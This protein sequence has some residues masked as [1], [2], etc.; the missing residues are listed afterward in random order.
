MRIMR[1]ILSCFIFLLT[2]CISYHA[3]AFLLEEQEIYSKDGAC[4]LRYLTEKNIKGWY[5]VSNQFNCPNEGWIDGYHDITIYNA[6]SQVEERIYGYFS[7]GYWTGDA[8]VSAP[9]L[10][11]FSEEAGVQK[12]TFL[13]AKDDSNEMDYIGQMTATKNKEGDYSSFHVCNPFKLL[14]VTEKIPYFANKKRQQLIFK[15]IE[16][17]VRTICPSEEKVMLFVSPVIEPRQDDI[18]FY[19]EIDLKKHTSKNTWQE[20]ALKKS[21]YYSKTIEIANLDNVVNPNT[22]DLDE[23][24][25]ILSKKIDLLPFKSVTDK[26]YPATFD[27][28][29][30]SNLSNEETEDIAEIETEETVIKKSAPVSFTEETEEIPHE[31]APENEILNEDFIFPTPQKRYLYKEKDKGYLSDPLMHLIILSKIKKQPVK[32][33][34]TTFIE[35]TRKKDSFSSYPFK[36]KFQGKTLQQGWYKIKGTINSDKKTNDIYAI[37]KVHEAQPCATSFCTEDK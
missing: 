24:R 12:A 28:L 20:E 7:Y 31:I 22:K 23:L 1:Y 3:N 36:L 17:Q 9:F 32:A 13:L 11:R 33:T 37:V 2:I 18:V 14:I 4:K 30:N 6:F 25:K 10:T 35:S 29:S 19:S 27:E 34:F 21:G 5:I 8:F 15:E 16:K 26:S